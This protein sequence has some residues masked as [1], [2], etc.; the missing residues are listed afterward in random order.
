MILFLGDTFRKWDDRGVGSQGEEVSKNRFPWISRFLHKKVN[1]LRS[2]PT[3]SLPA[4]T[5]LFFLKAGCCLP[6]PPGVS[7]SSRTP[8][9]HPFSSL[10]ASTSRQSMA[11]PW[12]QGA[13]KRSPSYSGILAGQACHPVVTGR[14]LAE[15]I[16]RVRCNKLNGKAMGILQSQKESYL[17]ITSIRPC[18]SRRVAFSVFL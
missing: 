10:T 3:P 12:L 7:L 6:W 4:G 18:K 13:P 8:T 15:M 11:F 14:V 9:R 1:M 16:S 2:T 17:P 5:W